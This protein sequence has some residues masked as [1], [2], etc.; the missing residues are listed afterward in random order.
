MTTDNA[1]TCLHCHTLLRSV[2]RNAPL[3]CQCADLEQR[4]TIDGGPG[5]FI[6]LW[7]PQAHW[8]EVSGEEYRGGILGDLRHVGKTAA[9]RES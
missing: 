5:H 2:S 9:T 3:T 4:I 6:R 8:Q 7:G 1:V